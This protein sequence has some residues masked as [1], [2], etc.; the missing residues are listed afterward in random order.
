MPTTTS[1][2]GHAYSSGIE[3]LLVSVQS[4]RAGASRSNSPHEQDQHS[5]LY[6]EPITRDQIEATD[7]SVLC[8]EDDT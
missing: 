7:W 2:I 3:E 5:M 4:F 1:S 6:A 8:T